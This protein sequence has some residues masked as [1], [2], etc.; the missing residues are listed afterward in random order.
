[1]ALVFF[2]PRTLDG[3]PDWP[4]TLA[5]IMRIVGAAFV[6][7]GSGLLLAGLLQLGSRSLSL[8]PSPRRHAKLIQTGPYRLVRHPMYAGGIVL[9][10]GWALAVHG[11]LT[12]VYA[13]V[14][15]VFL[16]I[17]STREERWL[18]EKFPDYPD[19]QRRVCKLIPFVH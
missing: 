2:G 1:M 4:P 16:D 15:A 19:Y 9:A 13:T 8:L 11:W 18:L 6:V 12:L 5:R 14:L 3:L 10:Y 7:G 17:K